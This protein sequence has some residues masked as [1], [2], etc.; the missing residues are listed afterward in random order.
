MDSIMIAS[1]IRHILAALRD[2]PSPQRPSRSGWPEELD[3]KI[4]SRRELVLR[5]RRD[6]RRP[7][8]VIE[9][10][11]QEPALDHPDR[12]REPVTRLKCHLDGPLLR[13]HLD[14]FPAQDHRRRGWRN[15]SQMIASPGSASAM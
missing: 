14:Q 15:A 8:G 12:V 13:I 5:Q 7:Q 4:E 1:G 9:H 2:P 3:M 10:R 11:G 6:Q